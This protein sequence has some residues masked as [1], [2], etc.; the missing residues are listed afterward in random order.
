[1][2][3]DKNKIASILFAI[4]IIEM[5]LSFAIGIVTGSTANKFIP[6]FALF[7]ALPW[8]IGG[9]I[10]GMLF[11]GFSEIIKLLHQINSK[12]GGRGIPSRLRAAGRKEAGS[13]GAAHVSGTEQIFRLLVI[14]YK[15]R[16]FQGFLT[17]S[18]EQISIFEQNANSLMPLKKKCIDILKEDVDGGEYNQANNGITIRFLNGERG[19]E[20]IEITTFSEKQTDDMIRIVNELAA[21][22][23]MET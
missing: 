12:L 17:I 8:W 6:G 20:S 10:A 23:R 21:Q 1:M 7:T 5:I 3:E 4:G 18:S 19:M 14:K 9:F 22:S 13:S 11:I 16:I 15:E 2:N